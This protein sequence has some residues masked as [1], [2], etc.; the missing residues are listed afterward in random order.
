VRFVPIRKANM[1]PNTIDERVVLRTYRKA[2]ES[3]NSQLE[4]M[5][6]ERFVYILAP[7]P[8]LS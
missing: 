7:M 3:V 5:G 6:V 1:T 2:V 4:R 8:G